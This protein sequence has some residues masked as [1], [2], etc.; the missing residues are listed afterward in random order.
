MLR[1]RWIPVIA[2]LACA[3]WVAASASGASSALVVS[4]DVPSAT[5]L[6]NNCTATPATRFG[7][8]LPG[9]E[10]TTATGAGACSVTFGSSN[11]S[12]ALRLGVRDGAANAM[13]SAGAAWSIDRPGGTAMRAVARNGSVVVAAGQYGLLMR[14]V[15]GGSS[16][17][18]QWGVGSG[19]YIF[20]VE[21]LPGSSNTWL[22]A[23]GNAHLYYSTDVQSSSPGNPAWTDLRAQLVAGGWPGSTHVMGVTMANATTWWVTGWG[24]WVAKT[25]NAGANWS[26]YQLPGVAVAHDIHAID[27]NTAYIAASDAKLLTTTLGGDNAGEWTV[28]THACGCWWTMLAVADASHVYVGSDS[29]TIARWD[30]SS[31][32]TSTEVADRQF[33]P[34]SL[35]VADSDPDTLFVGTAYGNVLRS[36]NAAVGFTRYWTQALG[37][38]DGITAASPTDAIAVGANQ[39]ISQTTTGTSWSTIYQDVSKQSL[40]A[41]AADPVDGRRAISVGTEGTILRTTNSGT[42]WSPVA[43]GTTTHLLDVSWLD[44]NRVVAVG[45]GGVVVRSGNGGATWTVGTN[46]S[47]GDLTAVAGSGAHAWAVGTGGIILR[48]TDAGATWLPQTSGTTTSL[49]GVVAFDTQKV[50]AVGALGTVLRSTNGGATWTPGTGLPAWAQASDV[51]AVDATTLVLSTRFTGTFRS[52]DA[53]ATWALVPTGD[54]GWAIDADGP[55][56]ATLDKWGAMLVSTDGGATFGARTS[57]FAGVDTMATLGLDVIDEHTFYATDDLG[58]SL[59][60]NESSAAAAQIADYSGGS[61]FGSDDTTGAFGVCLQSLASA[62]PAGTWVADGGTCTAVDT[63]PW[64]AIPAAPQTV[65]TAASG[66]TGTATFVWGLGPRLNQPPGAYSASVVFEAIAPAA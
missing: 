55:V 10:A 2:L 50:W 47:T 24:G 7:S 65:A 58:Y 43:S 25:T 23:A 17:T 34:N 62:A 12:S 46:A 33:E 19:D 45:R 39:T 36:T 11:D 9:T 41:V 5:S 38:V 6:T 60:Q 20:D 27:L 63:D 37:V 61:N 32:V 52:T 28:R 31:Y 56:V 53:G 30:G 26:A 15:N 22:A 1:L 44:S 4:M 40:A 14:S 42:T 29:G 64:K 35:A 3:C 21:H 48:S 66:V 8:V 54:V 49:E 51:A 13:T 16:F 57:P 59:S 18:E